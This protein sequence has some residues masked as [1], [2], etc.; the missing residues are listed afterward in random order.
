VC[1]AVSVF[2]L[3]SFIIRVSSVFRN[4]VWCGSRRYFGGS[5]A[6]NHVSTKST[7]E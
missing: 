2:P 3:G 4:C 5:V 6:P 7:N 1:G